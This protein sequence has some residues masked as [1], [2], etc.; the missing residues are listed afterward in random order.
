MQNAIEPVFKQ[1]SAV[2]D[3]NGFEYYA[4]VVAPNLP[5]NIPNRCSS[6]THRPKLFNPPSNQNKL[7]FWGVIY[8][9]C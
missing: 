5:G 1:L 2:C 9:D 4:V 3:T 8:N 6:Q 7:H